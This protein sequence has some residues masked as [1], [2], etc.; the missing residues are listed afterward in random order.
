MIYKYKSV[1]PEHCSVPALIFGKRLLCS[2]I[3]LLLCTTNLL[4]KVFEVRQEEALL[5]I[6][7]FGSLD[8]YNDRYN[9][10]KITPLDETLIADLDKIN[11]PIFD[12]WLIQEHRPKFDDARTYLLLG[13]LGTTGFF[14]AYDEPYSWDNLIVLSEVLVIQSAL[15][16]WTKTFTLRNRP[17]VYDENVDSELKTEIRTRRSFY[18]IHTSTAFSLAAYHHFYQH[19][20]QQSDFTTILINY[21]LASGVAF[22]SIASGE[23]YLSDVLIG[24]AAGTSVSYLICR[25]RQTK[26][27]VSLQAGSNYIGLSLRTY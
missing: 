12:R 23:N 26:R 2:L 24:A 14:S 9:K 27:A 10:D 4:P 5:N 6:L 19:K 13:T 11:V 25:L 7:L 17:Y 8:I 16:N 15:A 20:T 1:R 18:S 3:L 22:S 21:L